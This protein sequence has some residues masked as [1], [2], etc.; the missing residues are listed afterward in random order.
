[1]LVDRCYSDRGAIK[2]LKAEREIN[3]YGPCLRNPD[4]SRKS[5]AGPLWA[6]ELTVGY[7]L[8]L[9][10]TGAFCMLY[11]FTTTMYGLDSWR[12]GP[13]TQQMLTPGHT[14]WLC[15]WPYSYY[16]HYFWEKFCWHKQ[17]NSLLPQHRICQHTHIHTHTE[18]SCEFSV[19]HLIF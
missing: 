17:K 3:S 16:F 1:M 11:I 15:R 19:C 14:G 6:G 9:L 18:A 13:I 10:W 12:F 2:T 5:C 4:Q 7:I 8:L